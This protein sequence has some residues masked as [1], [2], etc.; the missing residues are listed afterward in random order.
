MVGRRFGVCAALALA[1]L[2]T[3]VADAAGVAKFKNWSSLG[4]GDAV[5][6]EADGMAMIKEN[7]DG[8]YHFTLAIHKL[9]PNTTYSVMTLADYGSLVFEFDVE[10]FYWFNAPD[11]FTTNEEGDGMF[12]FDTSPP[13]GTNLAVVVYVWDGGLD[14]LGGFGPDPYISYSEARAISDEVV[15]QP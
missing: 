13:P 1:G 3:S 8:T 15:V 5:C 11:C 14:P 6:P 12:R 9:Q 10:P 2:A 7:R 4:T